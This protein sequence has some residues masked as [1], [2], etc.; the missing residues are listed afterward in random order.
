MSIDIANL[1]RE[2][3]AGSPSSLVHFAPHAWRDGYW[4]WHRR[5]ACGA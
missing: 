2:F 5:P 3:C 4:C 1:A